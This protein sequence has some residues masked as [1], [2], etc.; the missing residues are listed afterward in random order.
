MARFLVVLCESSVQ[1][2]PSVGK[3]EEI[4]GDKRRNMNEKEILKKDLQQ[5]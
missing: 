2:Q 3:K 5:R 4:K 1:I